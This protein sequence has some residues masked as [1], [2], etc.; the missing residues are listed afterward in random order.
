[1]LSFLRIVASSDKLHAGHYNDAL[2]NPSRLV[3]RLQT[4]V[5]CGRYVRE[6]S[7]MPNPS[8]DSGPRGLVVRSVSRDDPIRISNREAEEMTTW[9]I[10][11]PEDLG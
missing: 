1:M 8:V 7:F 4:A 5:T 11:R 2:K 10:R 6:V 9:M 3:A